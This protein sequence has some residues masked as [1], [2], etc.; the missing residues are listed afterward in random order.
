MT[1]STSQARVVDPILTNHSRGYT[2]AGLIGDLLMPVVTMPT[3]AAK[4]IE[5]NRASFKRPK[6][7]R[8]PGTRIAQID[9]GYEGKPVALI[10]RAVGAK[11]PVEHVDEAAEV[12]EIDLLTEGVNTVLD[13][14]ALDREISQADAARNANTYA[15]S[16]KV[17]L[18]GSDKWS[19]VDSKPGAAVEDAKEVIRKKTGRRPNTLVLGAPVASKLR[20]HPLIL[21]RFKHTTSETISD[22]MLASYFNVAQVLVGDGIF[23]DE[24]DVSTDIWGSDAILAFVPG[25]GAA[26]M[27]VPAFGY[28][29]RL[30]G[31]PF[32]EPVYYSKEFRSW[33]NDVFDE[34]S[35][36]VVG[37]DAGFLF[38]AAV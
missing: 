1:M 20:H 23:D 17:A 26:A 28:T 12:P 22:E 30:R 38:Q 18:A 31:H 36:E 35:P 13:V 4:R 33:M 6:I 29:Y 32:V 24:A 25:K 10:Q 8:A 5:F 14:V 16:N 2:Q 7:V 27:R 19:H 15:A 21:D 37:P 34:W 11:T 9:V 3:R